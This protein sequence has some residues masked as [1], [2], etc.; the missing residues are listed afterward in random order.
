M[1]TDDF[2]LDDNADELNKTPALRPGDKDNLGLVNAGEN[3][4]MVPMMGKND[5][6]KRKDPTGAPM[7]KV[8]LPGG[9]SVADFRQV[10]SGAY[11]AYTGDRRA[12]GAWNNTPTPEDVKKFTNLPLDKVQKIMG[13]PA[14][15][16]ACEARGINF[17]HV[18][19]QQQE[20]ALQVLLDPTIK[21]GLEKRLKKIGISMAVYRAWL[22]NPIFRKYMDEVAGNILKDLE[23]DMAVALAGRAADGDLNAIKYAWEVT[24]KYNPQDR[25]IMDGQ[26]LMLQMVEIIK[27]HVK[28]PEILNSIG[29]EL[30]LL[31]NAAGLNT[32]GG[33]PQIEQGE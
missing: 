10:I 24:G 27:K 17:G 20:L 28:D 21:G 14:Y 32:N 12:K 13:S 26:R 6:L 18:L 25:Q 11:L 9:I 31:G 22:K 4:V 19:T 2:T 23:N 29:N 1:A 16:R 5:T 33:A 15:G 8:T 30:V 7:I 3:S